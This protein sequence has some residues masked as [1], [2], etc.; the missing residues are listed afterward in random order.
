MNQKNKSKKS[1]KNNSETVRIFGEITLTL[2]D[3]ICSVPDAL[4]GSFLDQKSILQKMEYTGEYKS[5]LVNYIN[6]LIQSGYLE[7]KNRDG[8]KSVRLTKKG[9]IKHI[10]NS[11]DCSTDGKWR[12]ISFDIPEDLSRSR[13]QFRRSIKRI[14]FRQVQRSLW[15]SPYKKADQ[16]DI[17]INELKIR[18]YVAYIISDNTDID[19]HLNRLFRD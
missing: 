16:I 6:G 9:L 5:Q 18:K 3:I 2:L 14:G 17:I 10:E 4:V 13:D 7:P 12:F 15:V 11:N 8:I 1:Q 19:N